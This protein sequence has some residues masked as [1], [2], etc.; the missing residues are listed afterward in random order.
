MKVV[1]FAFTQNL[2]QFLGPLSNV[3]GRRG[4]WRLVDRVMR[5]RV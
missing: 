3:Q 2:G 5:H 4:L 1:P